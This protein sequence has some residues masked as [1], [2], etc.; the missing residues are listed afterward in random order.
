MV[1][2]AWQPFIQN[3]IA[4]NIIPMSRVND[5]VSRILRVKM[6]AGYADKVKPS[7]RLHANNRSLIGAPAHRVAVHKQS[8][9]H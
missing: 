8:G 7:E 6:R 2:S 3:T 4:Q 9:N 1:P 5:A